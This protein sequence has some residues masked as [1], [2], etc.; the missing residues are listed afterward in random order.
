MKRA[1]SL[2]IPTTRSGRIIDTKFTI[3]FTEKV[4]HLVHLVH[5]K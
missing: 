3:M 5:L 2:C 4:L 1:V